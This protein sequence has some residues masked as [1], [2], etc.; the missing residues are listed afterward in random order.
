MT[1]HAT[2]RSISQTGRRSFLEGELWSNRCIGELFLGMD[3]SGYWPV[4]LYDPALI[5]RLQERLAASGKCELLRGLSASELAALEAKFRFQFP[6]DLAAFLSAGVPVDPPLPAQEGRA[7]IPAEERASPLGWHNWHWLL[8]AD[9]PRHT[10]SSPD[11]PEDER[12]TVSCQLRWHAP[13]DP[14]DS[15]DEYRGEG[16][17]D[18]EPA[19]QTRAWKDMMRSRALELYPLIPIKGHRMMPTVR[20]G[21]QAPLARFPV[22]SMHGN[23]CIRYATSLWHW[24]AV[25]FPDAQLEAIVPLEWERRVRDADVGLYEHWTRYVDCVE[26]EE[27]EEEVGEEVEEVEEQ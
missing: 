26:E 7:P 27:D 5:R 19:L 25:E 23:D 6:P 8:R 15:D 1:G 13:P 4:P 2:M 3:E 18:A 11:H 24:L 16:C 17:A 14:D 9:V 10:W 20:C 22:F 21:V 12:D